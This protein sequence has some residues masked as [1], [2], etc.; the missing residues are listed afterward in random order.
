MRTA[1][2]TGIAQP[3]QATAALISGGVLETLGVPPVAGRWFSSP[4]RTRAARIR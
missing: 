1:N 3:D 4:T 2:V